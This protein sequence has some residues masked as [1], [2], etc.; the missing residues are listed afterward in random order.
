MKI[1]WPKFRKLMAQ[2]HDIEG[3]YRVGLERLFIMKEERESSLLLESA[4]ARYLEFLA[5][6]RGPLANIPQYHIA[7]YLGISPVSLSRICKQL[8]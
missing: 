2:H 6:H 8:S 1:H 7:S 3:F 4:E 5:S